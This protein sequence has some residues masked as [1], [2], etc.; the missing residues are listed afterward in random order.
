MRAYNA[1]ILCC[2]AFIVFEFVPVYNPYPLSSFAAKN[3]FIWVSVH[4]RTQAHNRLKVESFLPVY[5]W[6]TKRTLKK[7]IETLWKLFFFGILSCCFASFNTWMSFILLV[8]CCSPSH[9]QYGPSEIRHSF[10]TYF[11]IRIHIY[12]IDGWLHENASDLM[13]L[14]F[15]IYAF[16]KSNINNDDRTYNILPFELNAI[17]FMVTYTNQ[18]ND[19]KIR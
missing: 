11:V 9:F 10:F 4:K 17:R 18:I 19:V 13:L 14:L 6:M 7:S 12:V 8:C 15:L 3:K 2:Y 1:Y 5:P 16:P